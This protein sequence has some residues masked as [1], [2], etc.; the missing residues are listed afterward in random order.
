MATVTHPAVVQIHGIESWRGRPFLVV[1]F[2]AGGTLKDRLRH[3]PAAGAAGRRRCRPVVRCPG[4]TARRGLSARGRQAEQRRVHVRR[5]AEAAGLRSGSRGQ[6]RR[7]DGR[8]VGLSVAR[9]ADRPRGPTRPTTSGRCAWC[10]TKRCRANI[11]S[12][13]RH[14][15]SGGSHSTPASRSRRRLC[16]GLGRVVARARV[17]GVDAGVAAVGAPGHRARVRAGAARDSQLREHGA[18]LLSSARLCSQVSLAMESVPDQFTA[19]RPPS[20]WGNGHCTAMLPSSF[21][22]RMSN[23]CS[24][25]SRRHPFLTRADREKD[26]R[27]VSSSRLRSTGMSSASGE[28]DG[29]DSRNA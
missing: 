19:T 1:E 7:H 2:L 16:G 5:V 20:F 17:H 23:S 14:R 21:R 22:T 27:R 10:C 3:G 18:G 25:R 15:R 28:A 6:R 26:Y 11:R 12:R 24:L 29:S 4:G 13:E 8:Y 9:G